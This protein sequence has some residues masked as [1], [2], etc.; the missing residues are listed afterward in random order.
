MDGHAGHAAR[1][2]RLRCVQARRE[3]GPD[4]P[5]PLPRGA[6]VVNFDAAVRPAALRPR[7]TRR[8]STC[9][10]SCP[11]HQTRGSNSWWGL[12][13]A[14][15]IAWGAAPRA[16]AVVMLRAPGKP[17]RIAVD[18]RTKAF[19][20]ILDGKVDPRTVRL[21]VDG[22][23]LE[24]LA[25]VTGTRGQAVA[26]DVAAPPAWR[27]VESVV[28]GSAF[29]T[30]SWRIATRSRSPAARTTWPA[31]RRGRCAP[32]TRGSNP[33]VQAGAGG[34]RA[35]RVLPDRAS[36]RRRVALGNRTLALDESDSLLQRA[37]VA[38]R[39]TRAGRSSASRSTI[40]CRP[41]RS[42]CASCSPACSAT[43]SAAPSCS[44][45]GRRGRW[46]SAPT[47][48]SCSCS[49][50]HR[51]PR[52]SVSAR[53]AAT[54]RCAPRAPSPEDRRAGWRPA[55]TRSSPTPTAGRRGST[56]ARRTLHVHR[57]GRRRPAGLRQPVRRHRRLRAGELRDAV[58]AL[59][60]RQVQHPRS[61]HGAGP[62]RPGHGAARA[63]RSPAAR[64]R[65]AR[66]SPA[67]RHAT[68][69]R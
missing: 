12:N 17:R 29:R 34:E 22:A 58:R 66:S 64:N 38:R 31:G 59:G 55:I 23:P 7:A 26:A 48:R 43:A 41:I 4:S 32:G 10:A 33:R 13:V 11:S 46:T 24:P 35:L 54:A 21:T 49:T 5:T 27:S 25:G 14:R 56:V 42:R 8:S 1:P 60:R 65:D 16:D 44:A 50:A 63:R 47:G 45:P 36:G 61:R 28:S 67:R 9:S 57:P 20:V 52:R 51:R 6:G 62:L 15:T 3:R 37:A 69:S 68:S 40:R 18:P 53:R 30:R 19:A 39:G 2:G